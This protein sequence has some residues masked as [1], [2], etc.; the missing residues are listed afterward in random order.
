MVETNPVQTDIPAPKPKRGRPRKTDIIPKIDTPI[1]KPN[2]VDIGKALKM[3][4]EKGM[5]Y[6]EIGN[7]FGVSKEAVYQ[8]LKAFKNIISKPE[9]VQAYDKNR[10]YVISAA[11]YEL[12]V[13]ALHPERVNKSSTLQLTT[14]FSQLF[15]K[16]RLIRG[17]STDNINIKS[18]TQHLVDKIREREDRIASLSACN[19]SNV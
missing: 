18:I 1:N 12:L 15:D 11:Q 5:T 6:E 16:Q 10:D 14:A 9:E 13:A 3:R 4:I 19:D 17:E 2:R 8:G 7:Q